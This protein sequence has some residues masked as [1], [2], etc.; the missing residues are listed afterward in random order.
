MNKL[1]LYHAAESRSMR[2]LW[3]LNEMGLDYD[4]VTVMF[5]KALRDPEYLAISPAGRVPALVVDGQVMFET[6]AILEYLTETHGSPL[7]RVPGDPERA[8]WLKWIHFSETI[9][10][11]L[12]SLTQQHIVIYEDKD[13]SPVTMKI[14]RRRL[15]IT[16]GVLDAHLEGRDYLLSDFSAAD[17]AHGY[18]LYVAR[19]FTHL[20]AMSNL[21]AY[22]ARLS[23]RPAFRAAKP[24]DGDQRIYS[25]EFYDMPIYS[26][27]PGK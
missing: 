17:I 23:E 27:S 21:D 2:V 18:G 12:A 26:S 10:Q 8:E 24:K 22:Y 3:L 20:S 11:H 25:K 13:R 4:L 7:Y 16:L 1:T 15:E 6:G 9:G 5:G 19:R 14:E